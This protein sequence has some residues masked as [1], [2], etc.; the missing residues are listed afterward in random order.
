MILATGKTYGSAVGMIARLGLAL[1]GVYSQGMM[2][3]E[4]NGAILREIILDYDLVEGLLAYVARERLPLIAYNR[5]GLLTPEN[6]A[7]NDDIYG[8]YG[9]P[10]PHFVGPMVGR[11][12]ELQLNKLLIG[13]NVDIAARRVDLEKRVGH[14]ATVIQAITEYVEVMPKGVSKGA[15]LLWLLERL[16]IEPAAVLAMGDGENDIEMLRLAGLGVT[17]SN[18]SPLVQAAADYVV[19]TNDESAVAQALER[20]VL[21]DY[22]G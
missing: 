19:G 2:V 12:R 6:A 18:A 5:D 13:D 10:A 16:D 8:K 15:G 7:Y 11:A 21:T 17:M 4:A 3:R 22:S 20:F 9:E 14:R 1:P